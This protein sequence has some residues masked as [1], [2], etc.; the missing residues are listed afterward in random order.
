MPVNDPATSQSSPGIAFNEQ[1]R[2]WWVALEQRVAE[3]VVDLAPYGF[4]LAPR[5]Y[6]RG[7]TDEARCHLRPGV[8]EAL[9]RARDALP[10]EH[11]FKILDAHRPWSIQQ[12]YAERSESR[13][14]DAHPDWSDEQVREHL[15]RM[16]PPARVVS[17]LASHRYGGAV[18]L[19]VLGPHGRELNMGVPAGYVGGAE[20]YLL[21]YELR[22][23]LD[24][25]ERLFRDNRRVLI[26]AMQAAGFQ[27]Y[28]PEFWHWGY[29]RDL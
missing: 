15:W 10:A 2:A 3:S 28:L 1:D 12:K 18:D 6:E 13:I 24:G 5:P 22:D 23:E 26:R 16:A 7:W 8:A 29:D 11:N 19:M 27:P 4:V 17:R 14:R 20:S 25:D 21:H 9:A